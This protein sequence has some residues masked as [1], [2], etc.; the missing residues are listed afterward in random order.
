MMMIS[1]QLYTN[2]TI[3]NEYIISEG[4]SEGGIMILSIH[5]VL[6]SD[7]PNLTYVYT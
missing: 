5:I 2:D 4:Y 3:E 1:A 6:N 7:G